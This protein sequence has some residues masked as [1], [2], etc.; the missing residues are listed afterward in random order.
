MGIERL[1]YGDNFHFA[2]LSAVDVKGQGTQH[3]QTTRV[4]ALVDAF[5]TLP[6]RDEEREQIANKTF[7]RLTGLKK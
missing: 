6:L 7:K 3:P 1:M 4:E 5:R 2:E